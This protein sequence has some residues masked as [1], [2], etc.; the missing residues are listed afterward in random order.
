MALIGLKGLKMSDSPM[1]SLL[2]PIYNVER[3]LEECLDSA[4]NQT[5]KDIEIICINDGSTD[6]SP[7]IIRRYMANDG[8]VRMID[9]ANSGYGSS[10]NMG[11]DAATG[12]YIGILESDDYLELD[13]LEVMVAAAEK[14]QAEVVKTDFFLFWSDPDVINKRFYWV[15]EVIEGHINPQIEREV[16]YRKPSIWSAIYNRGFL[17]KNDIRF[18][19]TPG[20][21]YQDAGFNFKVWANTTNAVLIN[22]AFLHYRQDNEASSVNSPGKV[23]CVCDEYAEMHRYLDSHCNSKAYLRAILAKMRFDTYE[24]NYDRLSPEL[25]KQFLPKMREDVLS[26]IENGYTDLTIFDFN[27]R[28]NLNA[29]CNSCDLYEAKISSAGEGSSIKKALRVLRNYGPATML[30]LARIRSCR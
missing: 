30:S 17:K 19:E 13:A 11:L 23:F 5:L 29:L 18:L 28:F 1:V 4:V 3:Y 7:D 15:D 21:S 9:K 14:Y 8:R 20:A 25:R 12:K 27:K 6:S 2:V 10:M 22:R 26:D 24:W 16:F